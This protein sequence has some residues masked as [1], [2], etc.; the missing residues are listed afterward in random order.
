MT[1]SGGEPYPD[2]YD[3]ARRFNKATHAFQNIDDTAYGSSPEQ[4]RHRGCGYTLLMGKAMESKLEKVPA[5]ISPD[6]R[7]FWQRRRFL[8]HLNMERRFR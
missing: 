4:E 8:V 7:N 3:S 6:F 5:T 2:G 1:G